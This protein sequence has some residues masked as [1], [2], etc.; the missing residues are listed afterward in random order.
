MRG[1][2]TR[3]GPTTEN[4]LYI[5]QPRG[6][7]RFEDHEV[8]ST[9]HGDQ[10]FVSYLQGYIRGAVGEDTHLPCSEASYARRRAR[11][12]EAWQFVCD[13]KSVLAVIIDHCTSLH[14]APLN[15][16][17]TGRC[18]CSCDAL[19]AHA[20]VCLKG[21][22][23][24]PGAG[25]RNSGQSLPTV[26]ALQTE[27]PPLVLSPRRKTGDVPPKDVSPASSSS[28]KTH[29]RVYSSLQGHARLD[30][31]RVEPVMHPLH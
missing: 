23:S 1:T 10:D 25:G 30:T 20:T 9:P 29:L 4:Y 22:I 5:L 26:R 27:Y 28:D 2:C 19:G 12:V 3:P 31:L 15:T 14:L 6:R 13:S 18:R 16:K 17:S 11:N 8:S 24:G 21:R 7:R